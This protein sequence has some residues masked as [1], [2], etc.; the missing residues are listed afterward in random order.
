MSTTAKAIVTMALLISLVS[1]MAAAQNVLVHHQEGESLLGPIPLN[2]SVQGVAF[3]TPI[4][5]FLSVK[6]EGEMMR[7]NARIVADLADLQ[8]KV[9]ALVDTIPLPRDN[10]AHFSVDNIVARISDKVITVNGNVATLQLR[11]D[12][13]IWACV[14]NPV[15]C[16]RFDGIVPKFYTCDRPIKTRIISQPFEATISFWLAV[17]GSPHAVVVKLGDPNV[18]LRGDLRNLTEEV[19]N[20][21]G[22]NLNRQ[23]KE[24]LGRALNPDV[25]RAALPEELNQLNA[26]VT[27]AELLSNSGVLAATVVLSAAVDL[28]SLSELMGALQNGL[29]ATQ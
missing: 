28:R 25:L 8:Q 16:T 2:H 29:P 22:V 15:P 4:S 12:V 17:E 27:R 11:G 21:L 5:A 1:G 7:I 19:L 13:D 18:R 10:C 20:L 24:L 9:G 23:V 14:E 3:S 6:P 26:S